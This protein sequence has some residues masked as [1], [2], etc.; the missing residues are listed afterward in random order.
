MVEVIADREFAS[1][2]KVN[3]DIV[4]QVQVTLSR[5]QHIRANIGV[6]FPVNNTA[7]RSTQLIFY[8]L[9]DWFDGGLRDGWKWNGWK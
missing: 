5:R 3:W 2:E 6:R 1:G 8:L 9:W 7:G 4:P